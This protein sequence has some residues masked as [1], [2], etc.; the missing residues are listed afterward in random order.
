[1]ASRQT[2]PCALLW[3]ASWLSVPGIVATAKAATK[4]DSRPV[5]KISKDAVLDPAKTYGPIV[6]KASL[7]Y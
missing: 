2:N 4:P 6:I 5:L 7:S 1:M 3:L